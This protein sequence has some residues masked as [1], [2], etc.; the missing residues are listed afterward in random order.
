M[1]DQSY[2]G[3]AACPVCFERVNVGTN[4]MIRHHLRDGLLCDGAGQKVLREEV[5]EKHRVYPRNREKRIES[6]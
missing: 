5:K 3:R 4:M 6:R 2:L 1:S